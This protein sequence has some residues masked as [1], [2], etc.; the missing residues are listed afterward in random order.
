MKKISLVT[1]A[2]V[3]ISLQL[4]AQAT[5]SR[6][7]VSVDAKQVAIGESIKVEFSISNIRGTNFKPPDF[8][9][10]KVLGAPMRGTRTSNVN[11]RVTSSESWTY[12]IKPE[13]TGKFWIL[14]AGI[15]INGREVFTKRI[16]IEVI[17]A[18]V[19]NAST[20]EELTAALTEQ[21]FIRAELSDTTAVIGQ[22]L[23]YELKLYW[24]PNVYNVRL[25]AEPTLTGFYREDNPRGTYRTYEATI[26]GKKFKSKTLFRSI[27]YP[28]QIGNLEIGSYRIMIDVEDKNGPRRRSFFNQP[29]VN[30]I[31]LKSNDFDVR[32]DALPIPAPS[33]FSGAVGKL[34][35]Q[36]KVD[37]RVV[38]TDDAISLRI[39]IV[40][41]GDTKQMQAPKFPSTDSLEIYDPKLIDENSFQTPNGIVKEKSFEYVVLPKYPGKYSISPTY[42]YFD[43]EVM[44]YIAL[45]C[46]TLEL[47]VSQGSNPIGTTTYEAPVIK[48]GLSGIILSHDDKG[49]PSLDP[50]NK[51]LLWGLLALP[52]LGMLSMIGLFFYRKNQPEINPEVARKNKAREMALLKLSNAKK[53]L[54]QNNPRQF[55]DELSKAMHGYLEDKIGI[56]L[57]SLSESFIKEK[58]ESLSLQSNSIDGFMAILKNCQMALFAGKTDEGDLQQSYSEAGD[59]IEALEDQLG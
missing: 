57:S 35:I 43:A 53:A 50:L 14:P 34:D 55:Y 27:I 8:K 46:D 42:S 49:M 47:R 20:D 54:D 33:D 39:K 19:N 44:E 56:P 37:Q 9:Y 58:L 3:L 52:M 45:S 36:C 31:D 32:V 11:G 26:K 25:L 17:R 59:L 29:S 51:P 24:I 16:Q 6:W 12:S 38:T 2:L 5:D 41:E 30:R 23:V 28:Q 18:K 10:F 7:N 15:T 21:V 4:F 22:P 13:K 40:G 1:I 48:D